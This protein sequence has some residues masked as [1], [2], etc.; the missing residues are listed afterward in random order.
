MS[1]EI[2]LI[3]RE[4][5]NKFQLK[6]G[7]VIGA[8]RAVR[9]DGAAPGAGVMWV[10]DLEI[11]SNRP[12]LS[13]PVKAGADGSRF[14]ANL[15][16]TVLLRRNLNGRFQVV[17]PGDTVAA[18]Q[19]TK[20]Y[21]LDTQALVT[22]TQLGFAQQVDPFEFYQ[23]LG[24]MRGNPNVTFDQTGGNDLITRDAGSWIADGFIAAQTIKI[25]GTLNNNG[26]LTILLVGA[27]QLDFAGDVLTDEGPLN[28]VRIGTPGNSR[29]NDGATPFPSRRILDAAGNEITPA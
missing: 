25:T 27:L 12:L 23:G 13:V 17:G 1:R 24:S 3:R 4:L 28:G 9:F 11:G 10:C 8:V 29:W 21:N 7:T 14:Y 16:Q 2:E 19:Q 20:E 22:T 5:A 6:V 18:Q 15:G 26:T